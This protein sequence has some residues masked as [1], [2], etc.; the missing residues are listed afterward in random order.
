MNPSKT[1]RF[2]RGLLVLIVVAALGYF[3]DIYDLLL[4]AMVRVPSLKDLG[5]PPDQILRQGV[6]LLNMQMGG[7][8]VGGILWGVLGDKRG[9]LSVLFGSI[10]LYSLANLLNAFVQTVDQYALLRLLAGIGLAGELGAGVTLVA[11]L[12]PKE[13]RGWGTSIVAA[14]GILGAVVG[15]GV[16]GLG[17][18]RH[19]YLIGGVLGLGLLLLRVGVSESG[20]FTRASA[21]GVRRGDFRMLVTDLGRLGRYLR[22]VCVGLPLWY[23]VGILITFSP[24]F[25]RAFG[26]ATP[27]SAGRA[28]ALCYAGLAVGDLA[29]GALSQWMRSRRR[30]VAAFMTAQSLGVAAFFTLGRVS[31]GA[32]YAC[33]VA[34]GLAGGYWALFVTIGAEQFGTNLRSTVATTVPNMVRGAVVP[35]TLA[36]RWLQGRGTGLPEAALVVAGGVFLM[37]L[38]GWSGLEET[39]HKDLDY[40][41]EGAL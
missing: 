15:Y 41:E 19:A 35:M 39:F 18:W 27:L 37:A 28:V 25:G 6:R 23:L 20:M 22:V 26:F 8:L 13:S 5:V 10:L 40:I 36:F 9:R 24:E 32:Y 12:S 16:A 30:A 11:E 1:P 17:T 7:L 29:S 38:W 34:L 14:V 31:P 4:F 2:G 21:T 3:V 33:C